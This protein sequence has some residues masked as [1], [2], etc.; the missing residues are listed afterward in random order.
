ML[1]PWTNVETFS[2]LR[3]VLV[4]VVV[5]FAF[6]GCA[7]SLNDVTNENAP[8]MKDIYE[9]QTQGGDGA[10]EL[11]EAELL[12]RP[13]LSPDVVQ[14]GWPP[15]PEQ[16]GHLYPRLPNPD[17]F[18]YVRPHAI[19]Q[20]GAPVPAY[21]TRFSLYERQPYALPGETL[22]AVRTVSTHRSEIIAQRKADEERANA[23]AN[24]RELFHD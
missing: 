11:R 14:L 7:S 12:R 20:S 2:K 17:L 13:A 3:G 18:M 5:V 6:T 24:E 22:D 9:R 23:K 10:L 1:I 16:L 19:G 21:I 4:I 8:T 15:Y